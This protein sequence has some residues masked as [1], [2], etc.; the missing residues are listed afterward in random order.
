MS[1]NYKLNIHCETFYSYFDI[2]L[3]FGMV[4]FQDKL[5]D[6]PV[7]DAITIGDPDIMDTIFQWPQINLKFENKL[8]FSPIHLAARKGDAQ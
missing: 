5:G 6:S 8:G 2:I 7:S 1:I 3:F 4:S